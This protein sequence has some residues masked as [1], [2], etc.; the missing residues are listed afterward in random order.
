M[1]DKHYFRHSF[2]FIA[3]TDTE[4]YHPGRKYYKIIPWNIFF[5]NHFCNYYKIIPPEDFLCN[6]A[7]TGVSLLQ[8]N[9]P[10]NLLCKVI[11]L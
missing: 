7:A 3:D 1:V 4:K 9:R 2:Y 11:L 6:V 8:Q 5:C 10:R